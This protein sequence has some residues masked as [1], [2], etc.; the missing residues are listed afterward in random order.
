MAAG[1]IIKEGCWTVA[2][3]IGEAGYIMGGERGD[4][5]ICEPH[6]S[7]CPTYCCKALG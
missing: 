4:G 6:P 5:I 7:I 1:C 3:L 2:F